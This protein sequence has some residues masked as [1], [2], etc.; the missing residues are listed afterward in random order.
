MPYEI[1]LAGKTAMI[2]GGSRG[3]GLAMAKAFYEGTCLRPT[4]EY[5]CQCQ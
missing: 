4:D 3:L 5:S 1:S 2:T